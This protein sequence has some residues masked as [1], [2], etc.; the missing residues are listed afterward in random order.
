M[1]KDLLPSGKLNPFLDEAFTFVVRRVSLAG[2]NDL[3]RVFR[4]GQQPNKTFGVAQQQIG[5]FV[6]R[7]PP[8]KSKC[9]YV[10]IKSLVGLRNDVRLR[11]ALTQLQP[12]S[13][14]G[15]VYQICAFLTT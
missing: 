12:Q 3:H 9:Q 11:A 15:V 2:N 10:R 4:A 1:V 8:R 7:E 5:A 13:L 6:S 14:T